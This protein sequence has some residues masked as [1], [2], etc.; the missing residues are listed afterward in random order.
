MKNTRDLI[1][2]TLAVTRQATINKLAAQLE[3]NP[4][5]VRNHLQLLEEEELIKTSERRHGVGRP[6]MVYQLTNKG[7]QEVTSNYRYLTESLLSMIEQRIGSNS[8][9]EML[10]TIGQEMAL[11]HNLEFNP[12]LSEWMDSFCD[13]MAEQ[14]YQVDWEMNENRVYIRNASCPYH[15]LKQTYPEIC[16]LDRSLFSN[17]LAKELCFE[18]ALSAKGSACIYSY[19]V[20][21]D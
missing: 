9:A 21:N 1:L 20:F 10:E 4:I 11:A 16:S 7:Q 15:H 8:L 18:K 12:N 17:L 14:G 19:E 6:H 5:T 2:K 3:I 13:L